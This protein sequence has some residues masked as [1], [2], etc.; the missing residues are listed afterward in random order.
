MWVCLLESHSETILTGTKYDVYT[1]AF[2]QTIS[3]ECVCW[4][5]TVK[6]YWRVP[7][8]MYIHLLC[9]KLYQ[10]SVFVGIAQWNDI[11]GYQ[12]WCIYICFA[13]NYIMWVCLLE[14]HSETILTGTKY[15]VHTFA[16]HQN[17]SGECVCWN[18]TVKRYWRVPNLMYIHLLFTKLHQVSVFHGIAQ[19]N[20]IDE[21]QIWC[22]YICF[23]PNYIRWVC[24][25]ESHSETILT[26]TKYDVY[27]FALH[28]TISGECVCWNRTV[29][30]Y[31]R[32]P[33]MMYIHLLCTK[34]Y[35]VSVF[36]GIAQWNDIDEYQIWCIY[37]C[38]APAISGECVCWNRTV[39][40]Y[41]RVP[42]MM[43][44]HLLC[45]SYIRRVC[46]LESHSE[47]IL[48]STK[49]DVYTFALH[50]LYQA[51]VFVGISHSET[52][53][54]GNTIFHL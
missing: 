40:R 34:L 4:N 43:Y 27:T 19:W 1:F 45:T 14:S 46:L 36:V 26:S 29:K 18:R 22:I 41:W 7:N 52:I 9:T 16:L 24:L 2:H 30:R 38:F 51:S 47:T 20:D 31:W 6:W 3:C 8:M 23:A 48:T 49:Y 53:L 54:T 42:N 21:Y 50:Q 17:I 37:I 5:R 44:I 13:P 11:D 39:K 12:I 35:H 15:D 28:Q 33:N 10:V 25:L 32:V